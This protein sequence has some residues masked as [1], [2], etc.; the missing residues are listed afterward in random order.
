MKNRIF[1][2]APT[3]SSKSGAENSIITPLRKPACTSVHSRN[4]HYIKYRVN[5]GGK[6]ERCQE[7]CFITFKSLQLSYKLC[8][9]QER[10]FVSMVC[11]SI[12]YCT[13]CVSASEDK[14]QKY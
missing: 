4:L 7:Y 11:Y 9:I 10:T 13:V 12:L 6:T 5:T 8:V 3:N 1:R 14:Q 2:V